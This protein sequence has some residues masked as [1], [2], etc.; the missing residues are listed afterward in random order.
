MRI[1]FFLLSII[2]AARFP[3]S[4]PMK[5]SIQAYVST[6]NLEPVIAITFEWRKSFTDAECA[7]GLLLLQSDP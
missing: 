2:L 7:F 3:F 5:Y 4:E 1:S 6:R